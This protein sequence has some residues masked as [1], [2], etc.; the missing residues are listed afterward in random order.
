MSAHAHSFDGHWPFR[1][2]ENTPVF[3]CEHVLDGGL[4]ILRV[5]HDYDG[6][7][8]FHCGNGHADS[9]PLLICFG[10]IVERDA[11]LVAVADLPIGWGADREA[12]GAAW[13]REANPEPDAEADDA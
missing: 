8:Q 13:V 7:W 5:S 6:D 10:C 1:E 9:K 2:A 4:P 3:T 11:T 12:P